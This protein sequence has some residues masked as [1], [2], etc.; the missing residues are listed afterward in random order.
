MK[1]S[2]GF[3][4]RRARARP[5]WAAWNGSDARI[6]TSAADGRPAIIGLVGAVDLTNGI[7][8][9][10]DAFRIDG[11]LGRV[12]FTPTGVPPR[13]TRKSVIVDG[14]DVTNLGSDAR[15]LA[16][17][18]PVRVVLTDKV[19]EVS[20][21][22]RNARGESVRE[23]VVVVLPE[24]PVESSVAARYTQTVRP[25]RGGAFRLRGLPPG[26]YLAAVVEALEQGSEWDPEFQRMVKPSAR[27][28]MLTE[29]QM[30][31]LDLEL[32]P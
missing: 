13:W 8:G 16:G 15:S 22:V 1:M 12:P 5:Y 3:G 25:D 18:N 7:V 28:F 29:G 23:Y 21:S 30:L 2:P 4:F 14:A 11:L 32:R 26:R 17:A 24:E 19:A 27:R 20:G 10:D 31:T 9:Q 6:T